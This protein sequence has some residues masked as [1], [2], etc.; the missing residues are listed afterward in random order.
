MA[1]IISDKEL[2]QI[3]NQIINKDEIDDACNYRKFLADLAELV[4]DYMGGE[5]GHVFAPNDTDEE[6]E[7]MVS[8]RHDECVPE[9]GGIWK[10]FDK[11]VSVDEWA[12]K[13]T[14]IHDGW[15]VIRTSEV[16]RFSCSVGRYGPAKPNQYPKGIP[17]KRREGWPPLTCF[18]NK[19]DAKNFMSNYTFWYD[20]M[21]VKC[22]YIASKDK[23]EFMTAGASDL[24]E[25]ELLSGHNNVDIDWPEGTTFA[26]EITCLE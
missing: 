9:D 13:K 26:D 18:A 21:I 11:D 14:E 25:E 24:S 2:G 23:P 7:Y 10:D 17:S 20:L 12:G 6:K 4:T 5:V 3:I 1:K 16:G 19:E 22:R 15:K 8:I